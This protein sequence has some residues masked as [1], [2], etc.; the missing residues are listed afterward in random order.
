MR[1]AKASIELA[2]APQFDTIIKNYDLD[3]ALKE[4]HQLVKDFISDKP[5]NKSQKKSEREK[6]R[7]LLWYIQPYSRRS[8][9]I[10]ELHGRVL[11]FG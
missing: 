10:G 5:I 2:T 1:I 9:G 8:Y 6:D 3:I 11:G 7:A 4:A